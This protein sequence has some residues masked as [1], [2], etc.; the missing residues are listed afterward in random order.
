MMIPFMIL[1]TCEPICEDSL[2]LMDPQ[3]RQLFLAVHLLL[4]HHQHA[5]EHLLPIDK[6]KNTEFKKLSQELLIP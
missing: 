6:Y 2:V 1:F 4:V 5:L 3:P